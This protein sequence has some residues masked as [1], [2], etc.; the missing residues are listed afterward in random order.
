[1]SHLFF[2]FDRPIDEAGHPEA[3]WQLSLNGSLNDIGSEEGE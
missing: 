1:M 2:P 3:A